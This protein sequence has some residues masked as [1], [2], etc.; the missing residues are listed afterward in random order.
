MHYMYKKFFNPAASI[1]ERK[2]LDEN[3]I[4]DSVEIL[5]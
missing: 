4:I 3:M 5:K 2:E 1:A